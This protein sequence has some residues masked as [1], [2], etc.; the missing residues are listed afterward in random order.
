MGQGFDAHPLVAGR[1]LI[2]GGVRVDYARG[3]QGDSD[4]D[5]LT[6][7]I[8]DAILGAMGVGDIGTWFRGDDPSV[9]GA[10]STDLLRRVM[11]MVAERHY[12]I[13]YV[14]ATVI[15]E[16]PKVRP[17]VPDIRNALAPVLRLEPE[18]I[19]IKG[20]T[21]DQMGWLGRKE[22]LAALAL[23]QLVPLDDAGT[24]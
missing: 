5:V 1:P 23:I 18:H 20:T 19:S 8:I 21:T 9:R 6:H 10:A 2:L 13:D 11:H 7:A 15:G 22:G 4:G 14:D 16:E 17:L 3:L 24:E 12:R